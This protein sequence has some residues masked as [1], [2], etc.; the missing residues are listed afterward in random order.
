MLYRS[1]FRTT[2]PTIAAILVATVI[3][4]AGCAP[5]S[6]NNQAQSGDPTKPPNPLPTNTPRVIF[7]NDDGIRKRVELEPVPLTPYVLIDNLRSE[8]AEYEATKE[9]LT[10]TG[11]STD[12]MDDPITRIFITVDSFERA[13]QVTEFLESHSV[14]VSSK[15]YRIP[16][17]DKVVVA[18][19]PRSLLKKLSYM[20]GIIEIE[21]PA[22][23][24]NES[25]GSY[26]ELLDLAEISGLTTWR[27]AGINGKGIQVGI[28]PV[29]ASMP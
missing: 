29:E 1:A 10:K 28:I 13:N 8:S 24:S 20:E 14:E 22:P 7:V 12:T 2:I 9:A 19:V 15:N 17:E 16:H 25:G 5:A 6:Q 4:V 18:Y 11:K 21:E 3:T 23:P 27:L 26:L